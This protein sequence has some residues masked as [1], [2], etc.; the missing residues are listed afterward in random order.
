MTG[1]R[2][3]IAFATVV[4]LGLVAGALLLRSALRL[5]ND[6]E[7]IEARWRDV[8]AWGVLEPWSWDA[9]LSAL[10]DELD[11]LPPDQQL[12]HGD[13]DC[14]TAPE[15]WR[16]ALAELLEWHRSDPERG[17]W[18]GPLDEPDTV[19]LM[20]LGGLALSCSSEDVELLGATLRLAARMRREGILV[21]ALAGVHLAEVALERARELEG[22]ATAFDR[23]VLRRWR[24]RREEVFAAVARDAKWTLDSLDLISLDLGTEEPG[25]FERVRRSLWERELTLLKD[26]LSRRLARGHAVRG[27]LTRLAEE[28]ALENAPANRGVSILGLAGVARMDYGSALRLW[29]RVLR[30]YDE[31]L[32]DGGLP[33]AG[34]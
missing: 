24:P 26:R 25:A 13:L 9:E 30:A 12:D 14:R 4:L 15:A 20:S 28:L 10:V 32:G 21:Q 5:P 34:R 23:A 19:A 8:V 31:F 3:W 33:P 2:I 1:R 17:R 27:D 22:S 11:A 7:T 29:E 18:R 16:G 6:H